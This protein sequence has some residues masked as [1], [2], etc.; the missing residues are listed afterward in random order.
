MCRRKWGSEEEPHFYFKI[1]FR[2]LIRRENNREQH[3]GA[4]YLSRLI[5][6]ERNLNRHVSR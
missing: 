5:I 3:T 1:D 6:H 4:S 2:G